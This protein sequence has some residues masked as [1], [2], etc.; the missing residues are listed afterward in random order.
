[1]QYFEEKLLLKI[2]FVIYTIEGVEKPSRT[3]ECVSNETNVTVHIHRRRK[4]EGSSPNSLQPISY[5]GSIW[6]LYVL[7]LK[8]YTKITNTVSTTTFLAYVR[9][10]GGISVSKGLQYSPTNTNFM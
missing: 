8:T 9:V 6:E 2:S 5:F 1:M 4:Y 10:S 3:V 7:D